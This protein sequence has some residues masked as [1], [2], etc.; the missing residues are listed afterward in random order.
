MGS[1]V[2]RS[3]RSPG[4]RPEGPIRSCSPTPTTGQCVSLAA[5][6]VFLLLPGGP[7]AACTP[8]DEVTF[9]EVTAAPDPGTLD[10]YL[11]V[12]QQPVVVSAPPF[13]LLTSRRSLV[14]TATIWGD[15]DGAY[16][17][18]Q[19]FATVLELPLRLL[20]SCPAAPRPGTGDVTL[21]AV[22]ERTDGR[23]G[24]RWVSPEAYRFDPTFTGGLTS[25]QVGALTTRFGPPTVVD[26]P[27]WG[28]FLG[29]WLWAWMPWLVLLAGAGVVAL[30]GWLAWLRSSPRGPGG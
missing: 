10:R 6:V 19:R 16:I 4:N 22:Y 9:A 7:A 14:A 21:T 30:I 24:W 2:I 18:E 17:P 1:P 23:T 25:D 3:T 20:G 5:L 27:S 28:S 26:P 13:P 29:W 15:L 8:A 11:G 12:V